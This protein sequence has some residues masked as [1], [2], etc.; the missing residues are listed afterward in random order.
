MKCA[1][2]DTCF[3]GS[4]VLPRYDS[5]GERCWDEGSVEVRCRALRQRRT[6]AWRCWG[7]GA[8]SEL[9]SLSEARELF[10]NGLSGCFLGS[11]FGREEE[12]L[13]RAGLRAA[14]FISLL[15]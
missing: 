12:A 11:S 8:S 13:L 3:V 2:M 1:G 6:S 4:R 7:G 5:L 15:I 9:L 14:R 10:G